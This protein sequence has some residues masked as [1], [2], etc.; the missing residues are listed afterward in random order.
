MEAAMTFRR[1][2]GPIFAA[3]LAPALPAA[4]Q[5]SPVQVFAVPEG[6]HPHD[7]APAPDGKVWYTAQYQGALGILDPATG[8]TRQLPLGADSAPHGVIAGPDGAAWI[9]DGGLNAIVRYDPA[10]GAVKSWPLPDNADAANLNTAD[11]D[12]DGVL[13][14]TGQSGYYGRLDPK[15][16]DTEVFE[17]PKG[18]GPYGITATPA[19]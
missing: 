1:W 11:F 12:G 13:W 9:T 2:F 19:G 5:Q 3:A 17:A 14:F 18:R 7:V 4:A 10:D 6:A 8:A 16:G 15:S